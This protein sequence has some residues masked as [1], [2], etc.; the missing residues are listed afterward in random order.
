MYNDDW[1][2]N[3]DATAIAVIAS[4]INEQL[5]QTDYFKRIID[6]MNGTNQTVGWFQN[7]DME[8]ERPVHRF[9][10]SADYFGDRFQAMFGGLTM[11]HCANLPASEPRCSAQAGKTANGSI[12][13][14]YLD[15][16]WVKDMAQTPA[17]WY[18]MPQPSDAPWPHPRCLATLTTA[19]DRLVLFG[20]SNYTFDSEGRASPNQK[21]VNLD[22]GHIWTLD[23]APLLALGHR[24][25]DV[26]SAMS[27]LTWSEV[28]LRRGGLAANAERT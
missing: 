27:N 28:C 16:L 14:F 9:A 11:E 22:G 13:A 23:I 2:L 5:V 26:E 17:R 1:V 3:V 6:N 25:G 24:G 18:R 21:I 10:A 19:G 20:G 15:D 12:P 4:G 7:A 8:A